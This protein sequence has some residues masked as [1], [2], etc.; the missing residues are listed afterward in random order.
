MLE[1]TRR[2]CVDVQRVGS[3]KSRERVEAEKSACCGLLYPRAGRVLAIWG[4]LPVS[5]PTPSPCTPMKAMSAFHVSCNVQYHTTHD[6]CLGVPQHRV[7]VPVASGEEKCRFRSMPDVL[8]FTDI[9]HQTAACPGNSCPKPRSP[10]S[11]HVPDSLSLAAPSYSASPVS[12]HKPAVA[13]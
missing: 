5:C 11:Q 9:S 6:T 2:N 7:A 13:R 12:S 1:G 4:L 10:P 3:V 8:T